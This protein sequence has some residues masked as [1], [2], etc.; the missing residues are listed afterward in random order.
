MSEAGHALREQ[1]P[2]KFFLGQAVEYTLVAGSTRRG[3]YFVTA[4]LPEQDGEFE[5]HIDI[6]M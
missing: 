1:M 6:L 4:M 5:Y 3:L 2:H